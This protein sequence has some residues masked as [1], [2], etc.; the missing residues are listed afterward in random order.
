MC[1]EW[2]FYTKRLRM[3][4]ID[5]LHQ[6]LSPR[7]PE[8]VQSLEG[9]SKARTHLSGASVSLSS[10]SGSFLSSAPSLGLALM[11]MKLAHK[12]SARLGGFC[13]QL[14]LSE[15]PYKAHGSGQHW[16]GGSLREE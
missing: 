11:L 16:Q 7:N 4:R 9:H 12:A 10:Q 1:V 6:G 13:C 14:R 3:L 15:L 8:Q 2:G 5:K